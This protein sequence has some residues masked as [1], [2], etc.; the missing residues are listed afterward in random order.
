[1][2]ST[3]ASAIAA[4]MASPLSSAGTSTQARLSLRNDPACLFMAILPSLKF[5][6]ASEAKQSRVACAA[7]VAGSASS[8]CA[9]LAMTA[10]VQAIRMFAPGNVEGYAEA[11]GG[12]AH[13]RNASS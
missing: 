2:Y 9:L 7:R 6:I 13:D 5:V 11:Q 12:R 4:I 1:M 8:R 10:D 3:P